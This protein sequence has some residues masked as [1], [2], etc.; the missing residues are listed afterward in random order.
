MRDRQHK[1]DDDNND[2][3]S[4][5]ST[6]TRGGGWI[7]GCHNT[8]WE[9]VVMAAVGPREHQVSAAVRNNKHIPGLMEVNPSTRDYN[10]HGLSVEVQQRGLCDE[11]RSF[12]NKSEI[13]SQWCHSLWR[14][15]CL[16]KLLMRKMMVL[17]YVAVDIIPSPIWIYYYPFA[18]HIS[19][20][21]VKQQIWN[22]IT[23][24]K[25]M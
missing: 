13:S 15:V 19:N 6:I 8:K 4:S 18:I 10:H 23:I 7:I 17:P 5:M 16:W 12:K 22:C 9:A 21:F 3:N 1:W 24:I 11:A 14:L 25:S 20:I 2:T